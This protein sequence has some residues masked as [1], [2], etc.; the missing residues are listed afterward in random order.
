MATNNDGW[1][2]F[3]QATLGSTFG[4]V[5]DLTAAFLAKYP[6]GLDTA[7]VSKTTPSAA[8]TTPAVAPAGGVGAAAGAYDTAANRDAAIATINGLKTSVD[9]IRASLLAHGIT[10]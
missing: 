6:T 4:S 7:Y 2:A 1:R 5:Q 10:L 8:I 3:L 9:A